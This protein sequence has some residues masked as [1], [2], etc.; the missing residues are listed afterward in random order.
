MLRL[1]P[2]LQELPAEVWKR[3]ADDGLAERTGKRTWLL[4]AGRIPKKIMK[5]ARR[6]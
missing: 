6:R 3:L 4:L 1:L 2:A 5:A